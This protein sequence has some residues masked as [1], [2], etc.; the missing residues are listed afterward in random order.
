MTA[1]EEIILP[2]NLQTIEPAAFKGCSAL[3]SIDLPSTLNSIDRYAF[4]GCSA[5]DAWSYHG[6]A[7]GAADVAGFYNDLFVGFRDIQK[8][9][10]KVDLSGSTVNADNVRRIS[11][12]A[13]YVNLTDCPNVYIGA[14][15]TAAYAKIKELRGKGAEVI[16][17]ELVFGDADNDGVVDAE[18]LVI[19]KK[20][21]LNGDSII[22]SEGLNAPACD[23]N[24]DGAIDIRDLVRS[25][26]A[27]AGI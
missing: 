18:D 22:E 19:L 20:I 15:G 12:N 8:V 5:L 9:Y 6:S 27:T 10:T 25:K 24:D 26:K 7:E 2:P 3:K 14:K 17:P 16:A 13:T 11:S 21:L 1:L 4:E 23:A